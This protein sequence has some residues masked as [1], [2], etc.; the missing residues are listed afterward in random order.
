MYLVFDLDDTLL[1]TTKVT[2]P[3]QLRRVVEYWISKGI[4]RGD[5]DSSLRELLLARDVHESGAQTLKWFALQHRLPEEAFFHG[6]EIYYSS[7]DAEVPIAS[8]PGAE[9]LLKSLQKFGKVVVTV[10][11]SVRQ[12]DKIERAGLKGFFQKIVVVNQAAK[13]DAYQQLHQSWQ[14]ENPSET[15]RVVAIGDRPQVD[16]LPAKKLGWRTLRVGR[17]TEILPEYCDGSVECLKEIPSILT[18][19]EYAPIWEAVTN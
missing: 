2:T 6:V 13:E 1:D 11:D 19:W 3:Y 8:K 5:L 7:W 16:L 18:A 9:E 10:G 17:K 15:L 4:F 12:L 14:K